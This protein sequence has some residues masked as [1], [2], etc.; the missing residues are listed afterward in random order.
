MNLTPSQFK[1]FFQEALLDAYTSPDDLRIMVR[2]ELD[3]NLAAI[4]GGENLRVV[5]FNLISWAEQQGRVDDLVRG[6]ANQVPG[7]PAVQK[8]PR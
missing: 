7:N 8:L 2:L 5:M 1:Q 6:A 4:A 3:R